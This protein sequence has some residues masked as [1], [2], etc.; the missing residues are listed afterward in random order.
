MVTLKSTY[1][2]RKR[3]ILKF[4]ELMDFL[5]NKKMYPSENEVSF[6]DFFYADNKRIQLSY[7]ELINILKANVSLMIYNI[8]EFTVSGLIDCIYDEIKMQSLSYV[9]VSESIRKMWRKVVLKATKDPKA[10]FDTFVRKNEEIIDHIL[11]KQPLNI[12]AKDCLPAGNLDGISIKKTFEMHGIRIKTGSEN[13]R[14]DILENIKEKRNNLAHGSVS[15]VEAVRNN[16]IKD[17][18]KNARFVCLFLE[19]L[20]DTVDEFIKSK[21]YIYREEN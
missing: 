8:V 20:I 12:C 4:I 13:F 5:E 16:G 15:F 14:P 21:Q 10:N 7:Q 17:I 1:E 9:D 18:N 6:E 2:S 19:E 11:S 3:E